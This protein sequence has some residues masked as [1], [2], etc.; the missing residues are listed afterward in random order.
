MPSSYLVHFQYIVGICR[1]I[2]V[3]N[4]TFLFEIGHFILF[5]DHGKDTFYRCAFSI[6]PVQYNI[7]KK[8]IPFKGSRMSAI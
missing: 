2:F 8:Q 5:S 1:N 7:Y 4:R 6:T 3:R